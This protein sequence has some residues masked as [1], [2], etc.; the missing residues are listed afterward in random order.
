MFI[1]FSSVF[2]FADSFTTFELNI[3]ELVIMDEIRVV[4]ELNPAQRRTE[5]RRDLVAF[6]ILGLCNN[7]G[8]VVMLTAAVDMIKTN[9]VRK[10]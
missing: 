6:W 8:Y 5:N 9:D 3:D 7:Y 1:I 10:T 2:C 4:G